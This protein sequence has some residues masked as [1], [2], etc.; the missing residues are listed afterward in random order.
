MEMIMTSREKAII[1]LMVKKGGK[2]SI[3]S[4]ADFLHVSTRTIQ[5]DLKGVEKILKQFE[6]SVENNNG[7]TIVGTNHNFYR[8][9][10]ELNKSIKVMIGS[11]NHNFI[12]LFKS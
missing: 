5:R 10:Q 4:I 9:I 12:D 6:L 11:H 1:D 7:L 2:H 8:L 3:S